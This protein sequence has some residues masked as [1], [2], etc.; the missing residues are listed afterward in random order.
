MLFVKGQQ[1][2][3]LKANQTIKKLGYQD[4][5]VQDELEIRVKK[6]G[7]KFNLIIIENGVE[8]QIGNSASETLSLLL[9][10]D[11]TGCGLNADWLRGKQFDSGRAAATPTGT[12]VT[13]SVAFSTVPNLGLC[14]EDQYVAYGNLFTTTSFKLKS[15]T[16]EFVRWI[17]LGG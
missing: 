12:N 10:V 15:T 6:N 17:A 3:Y 9:T 1:F 11:G 16:S 4:T 14:P 5:S 7:S 8:K 2:G 13:F